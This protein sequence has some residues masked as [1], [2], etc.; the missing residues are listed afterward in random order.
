MGS[1]RVPFIDRN[2]WVMT[3]LPAPLN[4]SQVRHSLGACLRS[5]R[6]HG[7]AASPIVFGRR[8]QPEAVVLSVELYTL[9]C[10]L[11]THLT[12]RSR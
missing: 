5:F 2:G 1:Q 6:E 10:A 3:F 7:A 4:M 9:L 8:S 12:D 11:D